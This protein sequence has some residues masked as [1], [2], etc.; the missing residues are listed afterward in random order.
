MPEILFITNDQNLPE[1]I[2]QLKSLVDA[3]IDIVNDFSQG[4]KE[5]F[6][7]Q[8]ALVFIQK[9]IEGI[10]GE[11]VASQV[12][13]LLDDE[14]IRLVLLHNMENGWQVAD[15]NFNGSVCR[16]LRLKG[17]LVSKV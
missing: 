12:R 3:R 7:R 2:D 15:S 17:R 5:I 8:P 9:E 13:A 16:I 10:T 6:F 11:K 14:P 4:L 1:I